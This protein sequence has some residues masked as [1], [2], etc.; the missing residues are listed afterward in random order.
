M[1]RDGGQRWAEACRWE[2]SRCCSRQD[3]LG[4]GWKEAAWGD[5]ED[6]RNMD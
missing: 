1:D 3:P 5:R 6:E 2:R 4:A